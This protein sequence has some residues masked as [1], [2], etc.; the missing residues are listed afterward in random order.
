MKN[1]FTV[2]LYALSHLII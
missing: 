2:A 1:F